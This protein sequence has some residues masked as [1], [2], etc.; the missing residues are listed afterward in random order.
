MAFRS[1]DESKAAAELRKKAGAWLRD[2]RAKAELTQLELS[3]LVGYEY[4]SAISQIEGGSGTLPSTKYAIY[5][6]A[7]K[8]EP[9]DF[10]EGLLAFYDPPTH[11][12]L[13]GRSAEKIIPIRKG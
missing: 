7:L 9:A 12:I 11:E 3:E 8:M 5:A 2:L 6:R 13:F 1:K 10:V 4:Y